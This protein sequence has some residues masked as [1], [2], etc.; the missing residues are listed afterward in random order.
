MTDNN[1]IKVEA[2]VK[3]TSNDSNK[4]SAVQTAPVKTKIEFSS[5]QSK[6][7]SEQSKDK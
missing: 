3:Q 4:M 7:N 1:E 2:T 5:D 6:V